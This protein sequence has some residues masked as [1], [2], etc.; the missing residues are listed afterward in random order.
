MNTIPG[1]RP[2]AE[3]APGGIEPLSL[4]E[5]MEIEG[6]SLPIVVAAYYMACFLSGVQIGIA[7]AD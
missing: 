5:M 6:G 4:D 7:L 2:L 1:E 3:S